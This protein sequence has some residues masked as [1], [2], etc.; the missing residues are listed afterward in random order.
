VDAKQC[1]VFED[2]KLGLEAAARAGMVGIDVLLVHNIHN[3]YF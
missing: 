1:V 2:S 3:D